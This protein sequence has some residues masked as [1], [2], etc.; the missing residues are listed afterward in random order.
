LVPSGKC[1]VDIPAAD[2]G[3]AVKWLLGK[4]TYCVCKRKKN[5]RFLFHSAKE[6]RNDIYWRSTPI[7][8]Q[9]LFPTTA[10]WRCSSLN[11]ERKEGVKNET[12]YIQ[13]P[14]IGRQTPVS[15]VPSSIITTRFNGIHLIARK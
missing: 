10:R 8:K 7:V 12:R 2:S 11:Q 14:L 1:T 9:R 3:V 6:M 13:M 5:C 4:I 15:T